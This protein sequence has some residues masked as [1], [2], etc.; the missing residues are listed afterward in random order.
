MT[1]ERSEYTPTTEIIA[2]ID[3][4]I[5]KDPTINADVFTITASGEPTLHSGLG[6]I[7]RH[8]KT[9]TSKPVVVLTNGSLFPDP[10]VRQELMAAD[11]VMPS[12]DSALTASFNSIN[13]P[14]ACCKNLPEIIKG[15][16][17]F[18]DEFKG[19]L[20]LEIL[21]A[22]GINDTNADITALNKAVQEINPDRV[23][24]NTVIR[25]PAESFAQPL[26]LE[27][28]EHIAGQFERPVEIIVD[29]VKKDQGNFS[30]FAEDKVLAMLKRR[31]CTKP[32]ICEALN[33]N[34]SS[35]HKFLTDLERKGRIKGMNH[36][37]KR[38]Y[39][40]KN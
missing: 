27:Q 7:I 38:Y 19:E 13:R 39:Q 31:P 25:P 28:M 2:E 10:E 26:T 23:Q 40:T 15:I 5:E 4:L 20:W 24:L 29:F 12:L 17:L 16:R 8:I 37:G 9:R 1:C 30:P 18:N 35:A 33:I 21:L 11:I 34:P 3:D 32:D 6:Q 14:A 22:A 36:Y